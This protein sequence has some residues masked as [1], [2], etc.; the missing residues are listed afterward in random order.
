MRRSRI[1][2][3]H[4]VPQ[5]YASD[6]HSLRPCWTNFLSILLGGF[7]LLQTYR[8]SKFRWAY[9]IVFLQPAEER[10]PG[11]VVLIHPDYSRGKEILPM[12][13][14]YSE[15]GRD[16]LIDGPEKLC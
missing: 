11:I 9:P 13:A 16:T 10:P 2:Q 3:T 14:S 6:L 15:Q 12:Q 1:V 5:G 8:L 4:N 7:V